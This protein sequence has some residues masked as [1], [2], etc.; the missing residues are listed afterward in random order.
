MSEPEDEGTVEQQKVE[1]RES[2][3]KGLSVLLLLSFV[4]SFV[5]ARVFATLNPTVVVVSA[6]IHFHHFW[7]GFA[8]VSVAGL[9]GIVYALPAYKR[10]YT[11]VFGLGAGLIG[12][13]VGLLLTFGD[14]N[15]SL[16]YFFFVIVVS[17][18][19]MVV[20][21]RDR[22]QVEND[23]IR[24]ARHERTLLTG[25]VVMGVSALAFAADLYLFG[26]VIFAAGVVVAV[27]GAL[28]GRK[29]KQARPAVTSGQLS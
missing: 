3:P 29:E 15:S 19:S 20:L 11:V 25:I 23:V 27:L 13:E 17:V 21:L 26:V 1:L 4:T 7:Y 8:M 6:G 10:M 14:Y 24:L 22:E 28:W 2:T 12:D 5:T 9:L 18:G 16:T